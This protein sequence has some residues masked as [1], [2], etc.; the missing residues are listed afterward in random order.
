MRGSGAEAM[1]SAGMTGVPPPLP[2]QRCRACG[3]PFPS[4]DAFCSAC[5]EA[6][7]ERR[8]RVRRLPKQR[9]SFSE[10][11]GMAIGLILVGVLAFLFFGLVTCIA[12]IFVVGLVE[13]FRRLTAK[14]RPSPISDI[15]RH[16]PRAE[17]RP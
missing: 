14:R 3:K 4:G 10:T 1:L 7:G 15:R 5:G 8:S 11:G 13:T 17:R 12:A 9:S 2:I 16:A 6:R